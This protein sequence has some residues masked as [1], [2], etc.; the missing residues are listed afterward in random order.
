MVNGLEASGSCGGGG[1]NR[2]WGAGCI[3]R[4]APAALNGG[5]EVRHVPRGGARQLHPAPEQ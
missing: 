4:S 1:L 5:A 2:I 3:K